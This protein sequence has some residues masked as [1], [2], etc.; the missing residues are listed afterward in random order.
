MGDNIGGGDIDR[1]TFKLMDRYG[2]PLLHDSLRLPVAV[3]MHIKYWQFEVR[4]LLKRHQLRSLHAVVFL[5]LSVAPCCFTGSS[6]PDSENT[7]RK[8]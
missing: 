7:K 4:R 5:V 2:Y 1:A 8:R 6:R 3:T